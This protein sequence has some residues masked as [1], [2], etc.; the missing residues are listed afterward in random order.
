VLLYI[1]PHTFFP[2]IFAPAADEL[3]YEASRTIPFLSLYVFGDAMASAFNGII[4]GCGRQVDAVAV[5][6]VSYWVI[7]VPLAYFMTF[8]LHDG[9]LNCEDGSFF[10]GDRGLLLGMTTGTWMHMLL[11][12]CVVLFATNWKEEAR[13]AGERANKKDDRR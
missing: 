3:I 7:G 13:R 2:S 9:V 8:V 10:C 4:K 6:L 1:T 11:L 12:G 5:V